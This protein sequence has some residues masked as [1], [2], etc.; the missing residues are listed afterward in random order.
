MLLFF[1]ARDEKWRRAGPAAKN[2]VFKTKR[3]SWTRYKQTVRCIKTFWRIVSSLKKLTSKDNF[4]S[5]KKTKSKQETFAQLTETSSC[6]CF[7]SYYWATGLPAWINY[8]VVCR[9]QLILRNN[10]N[11]NV[12]SMSAKVFPKLFISSP[13]LNLRLNGTH[14]TSATDFPAN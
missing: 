7:S 4:K 3:E 9:Y 14:K 11:N 2:L 6:F 5:E 13:R 8:Y 10:A 12:K 1:K